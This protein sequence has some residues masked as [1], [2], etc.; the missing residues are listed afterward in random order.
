MYKVVLSKK[1]EKQLDNI[2]NSHYKTIKEHL[3]ELENN[4]RPHGYIKLI[5]Y[6]DLYRIR[7]NNYRIIY[8]VYDDILKVEVINIDHRKQIY[9]N[10]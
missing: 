4:P 8:S 2:P 1:A 7:I 6:S 3:K 10:I 9:K 5:G